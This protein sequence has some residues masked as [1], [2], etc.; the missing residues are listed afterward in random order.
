MQRPAEYAFD[1]A[2]QH[3]V[4]DLIFAPLPIARVFS[5]MALDEVAGN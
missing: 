5:S 4:P 2:F 3:G 1:P